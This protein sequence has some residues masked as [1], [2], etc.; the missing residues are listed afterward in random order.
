LISLLKNKFFYPY[1]ALVSSDKDGKW[2]HENCLLQNV[3][4]ERLI[5]AL[6]INPNDLRKVRKIFQIGGRTLT[7]L[8][9]ESKLSEKNISYQLSK[10]KRLIRIEK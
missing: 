1:K 6:S 8:D 3:G 2:V 10:G 7:I 5:Y 4:S 9:L